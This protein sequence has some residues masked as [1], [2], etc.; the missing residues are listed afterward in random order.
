MKHLRVE[1]FVLAVCFLW[2]TPLVAQ[3]DAID[4]GALYQ[5]YCAKCHGQGLTGGNAPS[6]VD[7]VWM[8]GRNPDRNIRFGIAQQGMP[9][10]GEVLSGDQVKAIVGYIRAAEKNAGGSRLPIPD[11]LLTYDY[12]IAVEK[13]VE[14]LEIPWAIDF[15]DANTALVT[16]RPGG[17]RVVK[18]GVLQPEPVSGTPKV[19]HQGQGGLMDVAVDP[20]YVKNGWIYLAYSHEIEGGDEGGRTPAMTRVVRGRLKGNAWVDQEVIYEA[21]H[22][23]YRT[24]RHH[25]GSRI[26]F[27]AQGHL[28]FSIGD[29]GGSGQ[30]QDLDRPNGKVHRIFTDGRIPKDNPFVNQK[31]ALSTIFSYGHRNP[32]GLS[33]HPVTGAVW[34]SEHGPMGGDELN[35]LVAGTNYGWPEITYG[36]NYNGTIVTEF[37]HKAGMAQPTL[38]WRPSIAVCGIDF[39]RGDLFPKW[40]NRLLVGALA[41]EEVR[42]LAI[43][44]DRVMYQETILKN[45]GRVRDVSSGADGAI[46]VVLNNPGTVLRLTPVVEKEEGF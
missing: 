15:L 18:N 24:T 29:R 5:E 42:L 1:L 34:D 28:Y 20:E 25:Y 22:E 23:T 13:W 8:Y 40:K 12:T 31:G 46:Y 3:E 4:G 30:A 38:F 21:P 19:L 6:L 10:F 2:G 32:Q 14:G 33:V 43:E 44:G 11:T 7:G 36:R 35:V 26:V 27:D 17:L 41:F 9:A 39:Y 45:A 16:E 37:E